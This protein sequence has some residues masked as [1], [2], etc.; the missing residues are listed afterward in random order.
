MLAPTVGRLSI[1]RQIEII[2]KRT[3]GRRKPPGWFLWKDQTESNLHSDVHYKM[4]EPPVMIQAAMAATVK[5]PVYTL[6]VRR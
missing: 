2:C 4:A 1:F 6:P 3:T 5:A